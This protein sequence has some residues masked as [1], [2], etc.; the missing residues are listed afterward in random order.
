MER[1][2][3][4]NDAVV[5]PLFVG[6]GWRSGVGKDTIARFLTTIIRRELRNV[7][8]N[9]A[10]P[11]FRDVCTI[12]LAKG[13]KDITAAIAAESGIKLLTDVEYDAKPILKELALPCGYSPRQLWVAVGETYRMFDPLVWM[14]RTYVEAMTGR[15]CAFVIIPDIRK[16]VEMS[17]WKSH[18]A[19]LVNIQGDGE[20]CDTVDIDDNAGWDLAVENTKTLDYNGAQVAALEIWN[21]GIL[22]KLEERYAEQTAGSGG[23]S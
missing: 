20:R 2:I 18:G 13:V 10:P 23:E 5:A 14:K 3:E 11:S 7:L 21:K 19:L 9:F 15:H 16:R 12:S 6:L 8:D 22:P 4:A 17:F 1:H